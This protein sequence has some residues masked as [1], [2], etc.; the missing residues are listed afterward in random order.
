MPV[1]AGSVLAWGK[2]TLNPLNL[3]PSCSLGGHAELAHPAFGDS[4]ANLRTFQ[5]AGVRRVPVLA[6]WAVAIGSA[7]QSEVGRQLLLVLRS[8]S[9]WGCAE[10]DANNAE[11]KPQSHSFFRFWRGKL[12]YEYDSLY[13]FQKRSWLLVSIYHSFEHKP[14]CTSSVNI[15]F[16][17]IFLE[18]HKGT[19]LILL[20][21]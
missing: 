14:G 19:I 6:R 17:G 2:K 11:V 16:W 3:L 15:M 8:R 21:P 4:R 5:P 10:T 7:M 9:V 18:T 12:V 20:T 13:T 1:K